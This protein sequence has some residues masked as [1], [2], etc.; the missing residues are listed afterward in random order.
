M[1][2]ASEVVEPLENIPI[3]SVATQ[4]ESAAWSQIIEA[5]QRHPRNLS[6]CID[7][8]VTLV[9]MD[10]ESAEECF[11][12]LP[13]GGKTITGP[14][15]R[16]AEILQSSFRYM[17]ADSWIVSVG[18]DTLTVGASATDLQKLTR[19]SAEVSRRIVDRNGRRFNADMIQTTTQAAVSIA[20]RNAIIRLIPD[21]IV[22]KVTRAAEETAAGGKGTHDEKVAAAVEYLNEKGVSTERIL[23]ALDVPSV[24]DILVS[25][26][27][28]MRRAYQQ[29]AK[30]EDSYAR[31]FPEPGT[32][33]GDAESA[34]TEAEAAIQKAKADKD[35]AA[36]AEAE[37]KAKPLNPEKVEAFLL[38]AAKDRIVADG[39]AEQDADNL[40]ELAAKLVATALGS[41]GFTR[42]QELT[43]QETVVKLGEMIATGSI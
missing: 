11:Y 41:A 27:V 9:T 13:R 5:A 3:D 20:I 43:D 39:E 2:N 25:G 35:A 31:L 36:K 10:Q 19:V 7:E 24:D 23:A 4:R 15:I 6:A 37:E 33:K 8:A 28:V 38:K 34:A 22:R 18:R 29:V 40:D 1:S 26:L 42:V 21:P 30:G 14:S 32:G 17:V 12:A 16:L